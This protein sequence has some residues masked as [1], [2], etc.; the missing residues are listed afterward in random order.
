MFQTKEQKTTK[1]GRDRKEFW[2]MIVKIIQDLRKR[3]EVQTKK[4]QEIELN[5]AITEMND[6]LE[7]INSRIMKHKN[8]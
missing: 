8:G 1:W 4:I 2:V 6:T 5:N 7:E 3:M